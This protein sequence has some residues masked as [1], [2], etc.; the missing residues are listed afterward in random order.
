MNRLR[1]RIVGTGSYLP[2]KVLTNRD[3]ERIVETSDEWIVTRTG[4]RERRVAAPHEATSDLAY[5]AALRA[6]E[7]AGLRARDLDLI[8]VATL[9]PDAPLPATAV[10]LQHR[11]GAKKAAAFDIAAACTGFIY[12]LAVVDGLVRTGVAKNCLLVGAEVLSRVMNWEDRGTCIIFGDGAGAAVLVP[13]HGRSGLLSTHLYAD[14]GQ[15]DLLCIPGGGSRIPASREAIEQKLHCVHMKGNETF[16]LAVKGMAQAAEAALEANGVGAADIALLVP[17]QAN[18]RIIEATAQRL[19]L[20]LSRV[21]VNIDRYGNTSGA[22]I[23]IALDEA[24]RE[25]RA[26]AGDLVLLDAF[27]AG[28]TW[29][30]ALIR[31]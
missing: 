5:Q 20:P 15:A 13:S 18:I 23:P 19:H 11:L 1:S 16:K 14:G 21:F 30:S 6:L 7:A 31:W 27:G 3:L 29:G 2:E 8:V 4:I 10:Y 24:V 17:H 22:T 9:T 28:F 26:A 25:G 12:G